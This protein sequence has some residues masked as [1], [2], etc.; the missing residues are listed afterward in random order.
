MR[1][2]SVWW[3]CVER[4]RPAFSRG[5]TFLWFAAAVAAACVALLAGSQ[6]GP[7]AG[8]PAC[9]GCLL[10]LFHSMGLMRNAWRL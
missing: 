3:S 7:L 8:A 5:R 10:R 2:W 4:L 6:P 9:Y 1:L